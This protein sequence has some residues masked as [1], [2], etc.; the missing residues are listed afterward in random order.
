MDDDIAALE[1]L[2]MRCD[3]LTRKCEELDKKIRDFGMTVI[4]PAR[5]RHCG[6]P[7]IDDYCSQDCYTHAGDGDTA[8]DDVTSG[9]S[10]PYRTETSD[11]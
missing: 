4:A 7:S 5:C 8:D 6:S 9:N 3:E 2:V 10:W 1:L 11:R